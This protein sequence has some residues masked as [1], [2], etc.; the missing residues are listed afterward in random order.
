MG[1]F[2]VVCVHVCLPVNVFACVCVHACVC[3]YVYA[4]VC[5]HICECVYAWRVLITNTHTHTYPADIERGDSVPIV[6]WYRLGSSHVRDHC[7]KMC[8]CVYVFECVYVVCT[9][10]MYILYCVYVCGVCVSVVCMYVLY[11]Y[12]R[13]VCMCLLHVCCMCMLHVDAT[14]RYIIGHGWI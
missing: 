2:D 8:V 13:V 14:F 12:A 5:L 4:C 9:C 1:G 7:R 6:L 11:V 10:C 3:I